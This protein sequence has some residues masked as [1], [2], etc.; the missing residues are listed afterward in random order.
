MKLK[1]TISAI[2]SAVKYIFVEH[3]IRLLQ[4]SIWKKKKNRERVRK[5]KKIMRYTVWLILLYFS[6]FIFFR[7]KTNKKNCVCS[8]DRQINMNWFFFLNWNRLL[9]KSGWLHHFMLICGSIAGMFECDVEWAWFTSEPFN[10]VV[11]WY[12]VLNRIF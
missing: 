11:S 10:Q 6:N 3:L 5:T 7:W 12:F 2:A 8:K 9:V 4:E 1:N